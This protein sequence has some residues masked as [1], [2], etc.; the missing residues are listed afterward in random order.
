VVVFFLLSP[1]GGTA[2]HLER[3]E[4]QEFFLVARLKPGEACTF[5]HVPDTNHPERYRWSFN[6][7]DQEE[8]VTRRTFDLVK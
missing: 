2:V 1:Y 7:P 5:E 8:K 6:A 4:S 3:N